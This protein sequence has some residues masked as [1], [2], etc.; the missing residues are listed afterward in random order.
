[1]ATVARYISASGNDAWDGTA[2]TYQGGSVGPWQTL[3]KILSANPGNAGDTVIINVAGGIAYT[4]GV[5]TF[6]SSHG[7]KTWK[8]QAD[9]YYA[10]KAAWLLT[11]TQRGIY[12][13]GMGS[14]SIKF[15]GIDITAESALSSSLIYTV[16]AG[17]VDIELAN[18]TATLATNTSNGLVNSSTV[19]ASPTRVLRLTNVTVPSLSVS[20][21]IML[22]SLQGWA[23]VEVTGCN[24]TVTGSNGSRCLFYVSNVVSAILIRNCTMAI[25]GGIALS[26]PTGFARLE[27][28]GNTITLGASPSSLVRVQNLEADVLLADNAITMSGLTTTMLV[29]G[30]DSGGAST[31]LKRV[32]VVRN[33]IAV[34]SGAGHVMLVGQGVVGG[35][36]AY[37]RL[38]GLSGD[39]GLV[40][41]CKYVS[42]HHNVIVS[43]A[44]VFLSSG[45]WNHIHHNTCLNLRG[46]Y[47]GALH[48]KNNQ[49]ATYSEWNVITDNIFDA[50]QAPSDGYAIANDNTGHRDN[51]IDRNLYVSSPAG[52][53]GRLQNANQDTIAAIR[54]VWK[55]LSGSLVT[56]DDESAV[57]DPLAVDAAGGD[58]RLRF[59]TP[60]A[61]TE[62]TLWRDRGA[63]QRRPLKP[64]GPVKT[65]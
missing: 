23:R 5:L 46:S 43:G 52:R 41:K 44:P 36:V 15:D 39:Y 59:G 51:I 60:C 2:R 37:N 45:G 54:S 35:E 32:R 11:D 55:A 21:V 6:T 8:I 64:E 53:L 34:T 7:G 3:G 19:S 50:S 25:N 20:G 42:V 47:F 31:N 48:W 14:G 9:P 58:L 57:G 17:N 40:L 1:M 38:T 33:R 30:L 13:N 56:N 16:D 26:S 4:N 65:E 63:W 49:D 22:A 28:T 62:G 61:G 29:L 27:L 12:N 10:A 24:F 18:C